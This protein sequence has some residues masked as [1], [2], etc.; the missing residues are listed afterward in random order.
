VQQHTGCCLAD[1][2]IDY[3]DEANLFA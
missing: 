2:G 3:H 1:K